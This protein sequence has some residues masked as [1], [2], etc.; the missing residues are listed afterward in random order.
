MMP[1]HFWSRHFLL[2]NPKKKVKPN[3]TIAIMVGFREKLQIFLSILTEF[4]ARKAPK[5]SINLYFYPS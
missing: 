4:S 5:T 2:Q 1:N 3:N